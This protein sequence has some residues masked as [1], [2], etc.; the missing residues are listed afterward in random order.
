VGFSNRP[1]LTLSRHHFDQRFIFGVGARGFE[2]RAPGRW[3]SS[4]LS[5]NF[6]ARRQRDDLIRGGW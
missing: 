6:V 3:R 2:R 4:C 5:R 1:W